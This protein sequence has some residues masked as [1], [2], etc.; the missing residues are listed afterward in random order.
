[1]FRAAW[2]RL[3]LAYLM[4]TATRLSFGF[5]LVELARARVLAPRPQTE[6]SV[7]TTSSKVSA[8]TILLR[9]SELT[10][11]PLSQ[12]CPLAFLE[13]IPSRLQEARRSHVLRPELVSSLLA[14]R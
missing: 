4:L 2:L 10:L 14:L 11:Q 9:L 1:M 6:L 3:G 12:R 13:F 7:S 5:L 8:R